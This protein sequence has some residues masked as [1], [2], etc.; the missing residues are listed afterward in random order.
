MRE[1]DLETF[2]TAM[3]AQRST[4]GER[5]KQQL[6]RQAEELAAR[7]PLDGDD[8]VSRPEYRGP[9]ISPL[10]CDNTLQVLGTFSKKPLDVIAH[11]AR[12][13]MLCIEIAGAIS[14]S[15]PS[16]ETDHI[17]IDVDQLPR[18]LHEV[19][20]SKRALAKIPQGP[21]FM[22]SNTLVGR[23]LLGL[24]TGSAT[25]YYDLD[26]RGWTVK[27]TGIDNSLA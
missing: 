9:S 8:L 11:G 19:N 14:P 2:I 3:T 24:Q 15:T 16:I 23:T 5:L 10:A 17:F 22:L 1:V 21:N 13:S 7:D 25:S 12:F 6:S 20:G 27:I 4:A 26:N 18:T